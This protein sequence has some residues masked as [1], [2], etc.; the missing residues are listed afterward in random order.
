MTL[1]NL[2]FDL[3]GTVVESSTGI[4]NGFRYAF[5]KLNFPQ[6]PEDTLNT[7]IGPPLEATFQSLSKGDSAWAERATSI[8][9]EYYAQKGMLEAKPYPGMIQT[10]TQLKALDYQLYI[11][12]SK[13]EDVAIKML[14][15]L[16]LDHHFKGIFGSTP[17]T[18][19]KTLVLKH[20]MQTTNSAATHSVMIGDRDY[21]IIGGQNNHV[22][23]TIGVLWGFGGITEL[24]NAG[25]DLII[26]HPKQLLEC[27][28]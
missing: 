21:D 20:A 12:T 2:F 11:A 5:D 4:I 19:T 16:G 23:K 7:F 27:V 8:Y 10:L 14:G 28:K 9:R 15:S 6:L 26:E 22:A 17:Q 24:E 1:K 18:P 13:K 25:T 3:D